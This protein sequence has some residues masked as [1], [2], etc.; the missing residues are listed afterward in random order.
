MIPARQLNSPNPA[1]ELPIEKGL[2]WFPV[3]L[4]VGN[5]HFNPMLQGRHHLFEDLVPF[6]QRQVDQA[7]VLVVQ[8][9]EDD[10]CAAHSQGDSTAAKKS[11]I[12]RHSQHFFS[13]YLWLLLRRQVGG[14]GG[15]APDVRSSR[16][17]NSHATMN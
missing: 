8:D 6:P 17:S 11:A 7:A 3:E 16:I 12:L 2:T 1:A 9:V 13:G 10:V 14:R 15:R 4:S 5:Q